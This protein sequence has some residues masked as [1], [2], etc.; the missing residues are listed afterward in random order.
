MTHKT[1][2]FWI[3]LFVLLV[4]IGFGKAY[5]A[6]TPI[7]IKKS[8]RCPVCGMF[9]HKYPQWVTRVA[10]KDGTYFL[11][12][13]VKDML[14]HYFNIAKYTPGKSANDIESM[15]VMDYYDHGQID[16]KSAYYVIGSDVLGPM[17][18]EL[19][20]F[21]DESSA[22]EFMEDHKGKRMLSFQ[23]MSM[24]TINSLETAQ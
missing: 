12:D 7:A 8:D 13:G 11:Y 22:Q 3:S 18:N 16:A 20:P 5:G 15:T 6:Q 17:G 19:I 10:M 24:E 21:K 9:V 14:K 2:A 4:S 23:D 1:M